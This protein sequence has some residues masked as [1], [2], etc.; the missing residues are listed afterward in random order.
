MQQPSKYRQGPCWQQSLIDDKL[1]LCSL[2]QD[3]TE[4]KRTAGVEAVVL[5]R[6][7]HALRL[8][9]ERGD[10]LRVLHRD[11]QRVRELQPS[12]TAPRL[13]AEGPRARGGPVDA[14]RRHG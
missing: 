8:L 9:Q 4:A 13:M 14:R 11:A 12:R 3:C 5:L 1:D 10:G 6:H 2:P 7:L